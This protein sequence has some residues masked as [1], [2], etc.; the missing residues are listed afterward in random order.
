MIFAL[1]L[2]IIGAIV[3]FSDWRRGIH[4]VVI[5]GFLQDPIRKIVPGEPVYLTLLAPLMFGFCFVSALLSGEELGFKDI[6]RFDSV[7]YSPSICFIGWVCFSVMLAFATTHSLLIAGIGALAYLAPIP[8][9]MLGYRFARRPDDVLG[10]MQ[11][12]IVMAVLFGLSVYLETPQNPWAVLGSVGEGFVFYPESGGVT[13]LRSG[14]YRSPELAGWHS[15]SALC[16]LGAIGL[17]RQPGFRYFLLGA[18]VVGV[19]GPALVL[20]GRRKFV[21]EVVM[22]MTIASALVTYFR[23]GAGRLTA[24]LVAASLSLSAFFFY[25]TSS[26][27]PGEWSKYVERTTSTSGDSVERFSLMTYGMLEWVIKRNGWLGSGA[28]TGSQGAQHFGGGAVLVGAAA[29]GGLGKILA[30][31]GLPG[32]LLVLWVMFATALYIWRAAHYVRFDRNVASLACVLVA[33]LAA[34]AVVFTTAHQIFGDISILIVIGLFLG[35]LLR[36]PYF[37][38]SVEQQPLPVSAIRRKRGRRFAERT[39]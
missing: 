32:V 25:I 36:C 35:T 23:V 5:A 15:A 38:N 13:V 19:I 2:V 27:L 21:V 7:L 17:A 26:E 4:F 10:L 37:V 30:E 18:V 11:T 3:A 1:L 20:T 24:M 9:L 31:L 22:F 33:F 16:F 34:N 14:L 29:E 6:N 12:H 8:A 28:G 39:A